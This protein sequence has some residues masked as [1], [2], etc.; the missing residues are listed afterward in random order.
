MVRVLRGDAGVK[1]KEDNEVIAARVNFL[2]K[3]VCIFEF[4]HV[5]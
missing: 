2:E 1:L 3:E 4:K 5:M